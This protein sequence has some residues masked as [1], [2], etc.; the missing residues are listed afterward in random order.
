VGHGKSHT[1]ML[2]DVEEALCYECHGGQALA[3]MAQKANRLRA[4]T[5]MPDI[6]QEFRKPSHHPVE[7]SGA[8]SPRE[9]TAVPVSNL[10]RHSECVDCHQHHRTE[11]KAESLSRGG[12]ARKRSSYDQTKFEYTLCYEC[13]GKGSLTVPLTEMTDSETEFALGNPSYHPVEGQ[14]ANTNVPSLIRPLTEQSL[15]S[16]TDCH[17]NDNPTGPRGPHGSIYQ[18]IL[19][20]HY[21]VEDNLP[22]SEYQ[23]ALCYDCHARSSILADQS[24]TK[25]S[26]HIVNAKASCYACHNAHGSQRNTHLIEFV[27][28]YV[29]TAGAPS[30]VTPSSS[31]RLEYIDFGNQSGQCFLTCHGKDHNPLSYP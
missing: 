23:Y 28:P 31:G 27:R 26:L 20:K 6:S 11:K 3:Q 30:P 29:F 25:H 24:F 17:N 15:M 7:I 1:P 16:C 2:P 18:P 8:H 9:D 13:H 21:N 19:F 12:V 10:K 14:G 4:K 22:E 5:A